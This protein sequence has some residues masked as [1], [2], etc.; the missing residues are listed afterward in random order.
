M[1]YKDKARD[2]KTPEIIVRSSQL[3]CYDTVFGLQ[4]LFYTWKFLLGNISNTQ[5]IIYIICQTPA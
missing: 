3:K 5:E 4:I 2:K 1:G